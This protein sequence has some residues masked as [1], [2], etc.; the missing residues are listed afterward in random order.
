MSSACRPH[1]VLVSYARRPPV[2]TYEAD[3]VIPS[4]RNHGSVI[5]A[6]I[7]LHI[8]QKFDIFHMEGVSAHLNCVRK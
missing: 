3:A 1:V 5:G 6:P 2:S 8:E 4:L 7:T